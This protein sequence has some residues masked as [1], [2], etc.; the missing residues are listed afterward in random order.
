M[1]TPRKLHQAVSGV[2]AG[3]AFV[4]SL[5][6]AGRDGERLVADLAEVPRPLRCQSCVS[7]LPWAGGRPVVLVDVASLTPSSEESR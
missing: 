6:D 2:R 7:R 3:E 4:T 5:C 1:T